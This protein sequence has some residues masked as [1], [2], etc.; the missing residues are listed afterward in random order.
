MKKKIIGLIILG[1][2]L[3]GGGYLWIFEIAPEIQRI[4]KLQEERYG[5]PT[6]QERLDSMTIED[7]KDV[8]GASPQEVIDR[9][10]QINSY[11]N[12]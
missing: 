3:G 9:C 2:F 11:S 8:T 6:Y 5:G 7:C 1:I 10:I 12:P 4:E